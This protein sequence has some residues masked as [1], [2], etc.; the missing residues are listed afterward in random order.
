MCCFGVKFCLNVYSCKSAEARYFNRACRA[1]S[2]GCTSSETVL[3][4]PA[5]PLIQISLSFFHHVQGYTK[6]SLF[7]YALEVCY[8]LQVSFSARTQK[9]GLLGIFQ[10]N[11]FIKEELSQIG[12]ASLKASFLLGKVTAQSVGDQG[13]FFMLHFPSS[14]E[15]P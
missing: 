15:H 9:S 4:I 14:S 6:C 2:S 7:L 3:I 5:T 12:S 11:S 1:L 10:W 8:L 13:T